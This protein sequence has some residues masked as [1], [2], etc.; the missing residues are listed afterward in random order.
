MKISGKQFWLSFQNGSCVEK[1]LLDALKRKQLYQ[2][3]NLDSF[4]K[5]ISG[6]YLKFNRIDNVNDKKEKQY[7]S[8]EEV[9]KLVFVSCFSY[10]SEESIPLWH[11]YTNDGYGVRLG[12][13]IDSG[14]MK[15]VLKD[16][17]RPVK[18]VSSRGTIEN[19]NFINDTLLKEVNNHIW[20]VELSQ[21]DIVYNESEVE[22]N[23]IRIGPFDK[24]GDCFNL[25]AMG[26][27][28]DE[29]WDY[30]KESRMVAFLRTTRDNIDI[31]DYDYLLVPISFQNVL[32][33]I[34]TFSPWMSVEIK[35]CIRL[36]VNKHLKDYNILFCDSKYQNTVER[37]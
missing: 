30:E 12:F 7:F 6:K 24:I 25:T 18:A 16:S 29:A 35:D 14:A 28:K 19:L 15:D 37:K 27:I 2:Y 31:P 26:A 9:S 8:H 10:E 21:R 22:K 32:K 13:T 23:R 36:A 4:L 20:D 3:T 33:I 17:T 5:I 34:V 11:I 1:S